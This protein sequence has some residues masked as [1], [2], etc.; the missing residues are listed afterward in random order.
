MTEAYSNARLAFASWRD[1]VPPE[2]YDPHLD[3]VN[4]RYLD[5]DRLAGV[6]DAGTRFGRVVVA[7]LG[8]VAESYQQHGPELDQY[9]GLGNR[10]E[11][12]RFDLPESLMAFVE[13]DK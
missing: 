10:V 6:R 12:I 4:A 1:S 8:P 11:A 3:L 5:G 9:D 2:P 7:E 13:T